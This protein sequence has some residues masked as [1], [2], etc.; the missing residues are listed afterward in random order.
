LHGIAVHGGI[1]QVRKESKEERR[2]VVSKFTVV[3][4]LLIFVS[5]AQA[6]ITGIIIDPTKRVVGRAITSIAT[7]DGKHRVSDWSWRCILT[8]A[9]AR[10]MLPMHPDGPGRAKIVARWGGTYTITLN[11]TYAGPSA[12]SP[13]AH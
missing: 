2:I 5:R 12:P 13:S 10:D 1:L 8:D 6:A 11:V 3:L 7:D 4:I 9:G